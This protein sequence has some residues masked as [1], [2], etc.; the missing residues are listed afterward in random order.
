MTD[1]DDESTHSSPGALS[2]AGTSSNS[3]IKVDIRKQNI[4]ILKGTVPT[5][6][7]VENWSM[8][9][10]SSMTLTKMDH[11][12]RTDCKVEDLRAKVNKSPEEEKLIEENKIVFNLLIQATEGGAF[13]IVRLHQGTRNAY[14]VY[15]EIL[16]TYTKRE[17]SKAEYH[18]LQYN[19]I[20]P[21]GPHD[22]PMEHFALR[23]KLNLRVVNVIQP[24]CCR[25]L[26]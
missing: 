21:L 14:A 3:T 7:R 13:D 2:T 18:R 11:I 6:D 19:N 4:P 20:P 24:R 1:S 25:T 26:P 22:D 23:K 9:F 5:L 17:K 15:Q 8:H 10:E 16:K 12:V